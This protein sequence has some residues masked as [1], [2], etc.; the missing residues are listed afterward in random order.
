MS[1]KIDFLGPISDQQGVVILSLIDNSPYYLNSVTGSNS[2]INYYWENSISVL[3]KTNF[4]PLTFSFNGTIN[5]DQT[6][7]ASFSDQVNTGSYLSVSN[8][9]L[10]SSNSIATLNLS[11]SLFANWNPP[12]IL[13]SG[14]PYTIFDNNNNVVEV[15]TDSELKDKA[16]ANSVFFMSY[17][18]VV[19]CTTSSGGT[20]SAQYADAGYIISSWICNISG[21]TGSFCTSNDFASFLWT[22]ASD[23]LQ[24]VKYAYCP[25]G[26]TCGSQDN[27][28]GPCTDNIETCKLDSNS[29]FSCQIDP[30]KIISNW[31]KNKLVLGVLIGVAGFIFLIIVIM[32]IVFFKRKSS[33]Q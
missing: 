30:K 31:Y 1:G 16:A 19:N 23:C 24:G 3:D 21:N 7:V 12:D 11:Q 2:S 15:Y 6:I 10:S 27:C 20:A 29:N 25:T 33:K 18:S 26:D 32:A 9:I 28:N 22:Q 17:P 8:G 14:A 13:L 5:S 4:T